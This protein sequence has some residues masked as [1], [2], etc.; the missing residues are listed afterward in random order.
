MRIAYITAGA[1]GMYCGSCLRDNALARVMIARGHDVLLVPTYTP[2]KTDEPN[3]SLPQVFMGGIS[4]YLQNKSSIFQHT[5]A[6]FD[7]LLDSPRLLQWAS[8]RAVKTDGAD[9][10]SL[11]VSMLRGEDGPNRK[12]FVKLTQWLAESAKPQVINLSNSL[13]IAA[14]QSI[15]RRL[16][17][18]IICSLTGED[19][20]VEGLNDPWRTESVE[21]LRKRVTDV[22]GFVTFSQDYAGFM[23]EFLQ[24][25]DSK[26][27]VV[28][29][30]I[31]LEGH[32][33]G[34]A[35]PKAASVNSLESGI[36]RKSTRLNSSHL[37]ISYA[38]FCL[39]KK[40]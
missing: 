9:L 37:G 38:V 32:W 16:D 28:P 15:R 25:P 26:L 19:L 4:V 31:S 13:L 24:I 22:D 40:K 20:F 21:L 33:D 18:P 2:T 29:V 7:R 5:P 36:D 10:G 35:M 6:F 39:K 23:A 34:A 8:N 30:G 17:V 12:E 11:T 3:V 14:A 1:A 27:F